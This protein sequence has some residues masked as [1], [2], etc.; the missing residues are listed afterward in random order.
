MPCVVA[1]CI[2][3]HVGFSTQH[4][5]CDGTCRTDDSIGKPALLELD[6]GAVHTVAFV[7]IFNR[8]TC[9]ACQA[10]LGTDG[11]YELWLGDTAGERTIMCARSTAP[12]SVGPFTTACQA[13]GQ[14]VTLFLPTTDGVK[15]ILNIA[16]IK[17]F[18]DGL[19]AAPPPASPPRGISS[20]ASIDGLSQGVLVAVVAGFLVGAIVLLLAV[21]YCWWQR[22]P[23]NVERRIERRIETRGLVASHDAV[24][25]AGLEP[26]LSVEDVAWSTSQ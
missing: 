3:G 5:D 16:E 15:R 21:Y 14:Y 24:D 23:A 10:W 20:Y 26:H 11:P 12:P 7:Q 2:D 8:P 6:L 4:P 19:Q 1:A 9:L 17:V 13:T 18:V 22:K 25:G